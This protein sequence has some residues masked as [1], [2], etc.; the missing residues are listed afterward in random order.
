[1]QV[2][3]GQILE[4][5][6]QMAG[7]IER[8][9]TRGVNYTAVAGAYLKIGNES[10]CLEILTKALKVADLFK[11]P[12]EKARQLAW[13]ARIFQEAGEADKAR[14][15]FTRAVLLARASETA[16]QKIDALYHITCEYA[17][18][19]MN[20]EAEKASEELHT[21]V[22]NPENEIDS[23][24]ELI[25]LAEIQVDIGQADKAREILLES[26]NKTR[27]IKDSWFKTERLIEIAEIYTDILQMGD[28]S[29][30][31]LIDAQA[32]ANL[33]DEMNRS[34]FLLRIV[35][36]YL[37]LECRPEVSAILTGLLEIVNREELLSSKISD[38]IEMAWKYMEMG[39]R[40]TSINLLSKAKALNEG[41]EEV[42][43]RISN[44][45]AIS[46]LFEE[47]DLRE[48]ALEIANQALGLVGVLSDKKS[49][50]FLLGNMAILFANLDNHEKASEMVSRII[51]TIQETPVKTSGLGAIVSE[52]S[53]TGETSLA[54]RLATII[55]EPEAKSEALIKVAECL[56]EAD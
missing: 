33:I 6:F 25:N 40:T 54:L 27:E 7:R 30:R 14:E 53:E 19:G 3:I 31:I 38:L 51:Q 39:D 28:A 21:L 41:V 16:A 5:A 10:R 23:V 34:Y 36:R 18:A 46:E 1:L 45:I 49:L 11:K 12:D 26:L 35:D 13:I 4:D 22:I 9:T 47:M 37:A 20:N 50:S 43:D 52:L 42:K 2:E 55:R 48:Q 24:C 56:A 32:G 8:P 17:A 44:L 29:L 15:Q